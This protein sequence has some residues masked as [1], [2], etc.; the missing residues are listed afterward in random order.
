M[1]KLRVL[2]SGVVILRGIGLEIESGA[3]MLLLPFLS[4]LLLHRVGQAVDG[5]IELVRTR[6]PLD[7]YTGIAGCH[8]TFATDELNAERLLRQT[9]L[10]IHAKQNIE[11]GVLIP[12]RVVE[13][14]KHH[15]RHIAAIFPETQTPGS[16]NAIGTDGAGNGMQTR[17]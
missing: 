16:V 13:R 14:G 17:K 1:L 9:T 11:G 4:E 8:Y 6:C 7:F 3:P 15:V 2:V 10:E 12:F 5:V